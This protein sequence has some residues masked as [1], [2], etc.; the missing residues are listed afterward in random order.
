MTAPRP[1]QTAELTHPVT[2]ADTAMALGS[3]EVPVLATPRLLAWMEAATVGALA[4]SL[5]ATETSVGT[6]TELDHLAPSPV[7]TTVSVRAAVVA[8]D[9]RRVRFEAVATHDDGRVVAHGQVTRVV[10]DRT[11]FLAR[12]GDAP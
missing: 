3:G 7:G 2:D 10:V 11:R 12:A 6:R 8:V 4:G 9:G 5:A 1:G